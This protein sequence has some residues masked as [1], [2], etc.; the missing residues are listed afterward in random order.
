MPCPLPPL[1]SPTT[2]S[3]TLQWATKDAS[4]LF[5]VSSD[6]LLEKAQAGIGP[7]EQRGC[8]NICWA[9]ES[10]AGQ[11]AVPQCPGSAPL[12]PGASPHGRWESPGPGD[13]FPGQKGRMAEIQDWKHAGM[14]HFCTG[15]HR[16]GLGHLQCYRSTGKNG[17]KWEWEGSTPSPSLLRS[18][19]LF[20][21]PPVLQER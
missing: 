9:Q 16:G 4:G 14:L 15:E 7:R 17:E 11:A 18:W 8:R 19:K 1:P 13:A 6:E 10:C 2:R 21:A 5:P 3:L 20:K 12:R